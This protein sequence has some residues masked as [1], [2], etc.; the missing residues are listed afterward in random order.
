MDRRLPLKAAALLVSLAAAG[1]ADRPVV[2]SSDPS[3]ET[4]RWDVDEPPFAVAE[5]TA[6][7]HCA[8]YG[9]RATL[10]SVFRDD[11]V[12]IARFACR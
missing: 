2:L 9:K 3:G 4:L 10:E 12:E 11:A 5:A 8:Q 7:E 6:G 1:C